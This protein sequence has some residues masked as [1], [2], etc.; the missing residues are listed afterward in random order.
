MYFAKVGQS[1]LK[2]AMSLFLKIYCIGRNAAWMRCYQH[3]RN[4][5]VKCGGTG[6]CETNILQNL[7]R[8]CG[9]TWMLYLHCM[10]KRGGRSPR[11]PYLIAPMVINDVLHGCNVINDVLHGCNVIHD[12][13]HGCNVINDVLHECNVIND[14]LH[15]CNVINGV[16]SMTF[17]L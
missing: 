15:E 10:K 17:T 8:K 7:K 13:L 4:F 9:G 3:G 12:V 1:Y 5:V 14:V 2:H 11:V 6:W 16:L